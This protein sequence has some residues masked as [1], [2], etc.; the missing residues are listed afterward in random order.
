MFGKTSRRTRNHLQT[1][2][3]RAPATVVEIAAWGMNV[4]EGRDLQVA[5]RK[6]TLRV[7]PEGEPEFV[8]TKRLRYENGATIPTAGKRI[9]VLYDPDDH[10]TIML[11]PLTPE[12]EARRTAAALS[13]A[14]GGSLIQSTAIGGAA[15]AP[16]ELLE[17]HRAAM[18]QAQQMLDQLSNQGRSTSG[19]K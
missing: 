4:R 1:H 3:R 18:E 6:T 14:N 9:E 13:K 7:E 5:V 11:A 2:G 8:I 16:E 15:A 10:E 17:Q 19:G 12:Q